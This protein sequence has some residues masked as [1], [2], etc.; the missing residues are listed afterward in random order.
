M[1]QVSLVLMSQQLWVGSWM[2]AAHRKSQAMIRS[3]PLLILLRRERAG[4]RI[5][6]WSCLHEEASIKPQK[7]ELREFSGWQTYKTVTH[8]NSTGQRSSCTQSKTSP[9]VS[10]H[11]RLYDSFIISFN[12]L[13]N[14]RVSP[15]FHEPL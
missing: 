3:T 7:C 15:E 10:L 1:I 12:I 11:L 8:P 2:R 6:D 9:C 14:M 13:V 5:N 4:N